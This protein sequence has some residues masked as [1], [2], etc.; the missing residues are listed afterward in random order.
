MDNNR[1]DFAIY[2]KSDCVHNDQK[3]LFCSVFYCLRGSV[4]TLSSGSLFSY[5]MTAT[6][7]QIRQQIVRLRHKGN[8]R[9]GAVANIVKK[10]KSVIHGILKVYDNTGSCEAGKSTGRP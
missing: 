8:L 3:G 6:P 4:F 9:I 2:G 10:S 5:K 7:L 1:N